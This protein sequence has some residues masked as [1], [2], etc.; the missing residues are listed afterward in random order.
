MVPLMLP[1]AFS[2]NARWALPLHICVS[3][4]GPA[5]HCNRPVWSALI[6]SSEPWTSHLPTY[7]GKTEGAVCVG[8]GE[9]W[10]VWDAWGAWEADNE[11]HPQSS[12]SVSRSKPP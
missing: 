3:E 12:T 9:G 7:E 6:A 8:V 11:L 10:E 2:V 5:F 4:H 1:S